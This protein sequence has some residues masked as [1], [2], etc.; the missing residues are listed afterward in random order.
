MRQHVSLEVRFGFEGFTISAM[1]TVELPPDS[2]SAHCD[3]I[4][5]GNKVDPRLA[6]ALSLAFGGHKRLVDAGN[7]ITIGRRSA[8]KL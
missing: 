2:I 3:A 8:I 1:R 4:D 7:D 5:D 6:I